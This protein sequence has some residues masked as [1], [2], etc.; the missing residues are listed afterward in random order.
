MENNKDYEIGYGKPP[1]NTRFTKGHSGNP[2]GRKKKIIPDTLFQAISLELCQQ[3]TITDASGLKEKVPLYSILAKKLVQDAIQNDGP[4][5]K[6]LL[7]TNNL[8]KCNFNDIVKSLHERQ[9]PVESE[10]TGDERIRLVKHL[11]EMYDK[12]LSEEQQE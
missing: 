10:F 1:K 8:F 5:R 12:L 4:S 2:A 3:K 9:N 7:Q 11:H 6:F